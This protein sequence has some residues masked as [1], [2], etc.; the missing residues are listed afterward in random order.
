MTTKDIEVIPVEQSSSGTPSHTNTRVE[1]NFNSNMHDLKN[2]SMPKNTVL[3]NRKVR[4]TRNMSITY[5]VSI[6]RKIRIA[7]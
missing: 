4:R 3:M 5:D 7:K 6:A 1:S 2:E